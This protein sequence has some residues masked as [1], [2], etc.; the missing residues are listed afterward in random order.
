V[1]RRR[2]LWRRREW[3]FLLIFGALSLVRQSLGA[4]R[5]TSRGF[6]EGV[7]FEYFKLRLLRC[8]RVLLV[9]ECSFLAITC[10]VVII[11]LLLLPLLH[12]RSSIRTVLYCLRDSGFPLRSP[13]SNTH[14]RYSD[15]N[16]L[17]I[18]GSSDTFNAFQKQ[19]QSERLTEGPSKILVVRSVGGF[20]SKI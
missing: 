7:A 6:L 8:A 20:A 10:L 15:K 17:K 18:H 4:M 5:C 2:L 3:L 19:M 1:G 16:A 12:L 9:V 14:H 13:N 11:S